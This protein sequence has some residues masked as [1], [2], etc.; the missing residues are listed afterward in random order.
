LLVDG[1]EIEGCIALREVSADICEMKRFYVRPSARGR[2][3][4]I[5]WW[6]D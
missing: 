6:S 2:K 3:V 1:G 4:G 5:S